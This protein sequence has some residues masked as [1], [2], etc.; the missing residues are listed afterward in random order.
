MPVS[1]GRITKT[2]K[3]KGA[4]TH[5]KNH[6][7]ESFNN[8]IAQIGALDP[9]HRVRR[10]DLGTED[11][12]TTTSYFQ[13]GLQ[14]WSE[15]NL[16]RGFIAFKRAVMPLC[17]SL[18]QL[19]HFESRIM[20]LLAEHIAAHEKASLEP[21]L[22]LLTA[23]ARDLGVR[24]EKHYGR[25][26]ELISGILAKPQDVDV[27]EWT[28]G[29]LAW[30]F[31]YLWRLLVPNLCPTYDMLAPLLGRSRHT[32]HVARFAAEAMS[33]LVTKAAAPSNRQTALGKIVAHIRDDL[34][35]M[36]G[37][38]QFTLYRDGIMAM[39]AEAIKGTGEAIH[40]SGPALAQALLA[41][42]PEAERE[43]NPNPIWTSVICGALTSV[44]HGSNATAM[45]EL[46]AAIVGYIRSD[47]ENGSFAHLPWRCLPWC[48][49]I[50]TLAGVR[51]GSRV[52]EWPPLV[53][54]FIRLVESFSMAQPG[55]VDVMDGLLW[56]DV[57][58]NAAIVWH[59]APMDTLIKH[60]TAFTHTITH[61]PFVQWFIPFCVYLHQLDSGRFSSLFRQDFQKWVAVF[62][63][64]PP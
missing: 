42:L 58:V 36:A 59:Q 35:S 16:A 11:L 54:A 37:D 18:P 43:P 29:S 10:H 45:T 48:R 56:R 41:A 44:L 4:P 30:L 33:F 13:K 5:G 28:F 7:W 47:V 25:A 39:F 52:A 26:L 6:R 53:D 20:E 62:F 15:L 34:Y 32:P 31:K 21:L 19:L 14:R 22:D 9:L 27:I 17:E 60:K 12:S 55:A 23:F 51:G 64:P 40:T 57:I 3:G 50:G 8:K 24:F 63:S 38:R 46:V 1:S 2:R 49:V 61:E